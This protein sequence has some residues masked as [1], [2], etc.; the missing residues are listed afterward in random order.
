MSDD[1]SLLIWLTATAFHGTSFNGPSL[2]KTLRG[3]TAAQAASEA[4]YEG[5]SAWGVALHLMYWKHELTEALNA[6]MGEPFPPANF[7][8]EGKDF[9]LLPKVLTEDAWTEARAELAAQ[10][11]FY[12][13]ALRSFPVM[14]LDEK[15]AWG[16]TFGEAIAWM[17]THDTYHTAMI[18]NMGVPGLRENR[19]ESSR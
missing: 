5:Y 15:M 16:C 7:P 14:R 18:R 12:M 19:D 8:Y 11:T 3:L 17:A 1:L 9:P 6:A 4:T 10:H 2:M 13:V